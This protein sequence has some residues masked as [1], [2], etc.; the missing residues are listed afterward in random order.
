MICIETIRFLQVSIADLALNFIL[1]LA[2][3]GRRS[4]RKGRITQGGEGSKCLSS[5]PLI[6]A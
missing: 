1:G 6:T 2:I 5:N 4:V 3:V